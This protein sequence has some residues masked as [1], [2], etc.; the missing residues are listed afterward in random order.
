VRWAAR[1]GAQLVFHPHCAGND[2][3]GR[4]LTEWR[5]PGNPYYESAMMCRAL[6][7]TIYFASVNYGFAYADSASTVVDP[8]G[9]LVA[10]QP[11]GKPG[12]LVA[13]LDLVKATGRLAARCTLSEY[14]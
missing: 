13:E 1:Q 9:A 11:Y 4:R 10:H 2:R 14:Y 6:E 12:V 7:N 3:K 8:S 5:A